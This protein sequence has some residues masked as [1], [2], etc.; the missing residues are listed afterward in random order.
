LR[1]FCQEKPYRIIIRWNEC[2]EAA[3]D[4]EL[5]ALCSSS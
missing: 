1:N 4:E 3:L 5:F 2:C